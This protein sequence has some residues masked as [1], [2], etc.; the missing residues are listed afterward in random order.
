MVFSNVLE[1]LCDADKVLRQSRDLFSA[2]RKVLVSLPNVTYFENRLGR[3][4]G[5]SN[6]TEGNP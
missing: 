4:K 5:D 6:Y 2:G 1:Q 3:F